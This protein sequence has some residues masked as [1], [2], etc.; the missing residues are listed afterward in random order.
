MQRD[1]HAEIA[2]KLRDRG[3][4]RTMRR[5]I[6]LLTKMAVTLVVTS[7]V[8]LAV[9]KIGTNGPDTLRGT[10]RADNLLGRDGNDILYGL[11]GKDNMLGGSGKDA[12]LGGNKRTPLKGEKNVVGGT[13]ND[14]ILGGQNSD[15]LVG[16]DG[17][18]YFYDGGVEGGPV[19]HD[20]VLGGDG[21]DVIIIFNDSSA[22][23]IAVCGDGI[24]RVLSD[25]LRLGEDTVAP[26]CEKVFVGRGAID[27]FN[28]SIPQ[29]FWDGLPP[30]P[31]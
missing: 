10:N 8:A 12:I 15:N 4:E 24:D 27:E 21:N 31:S 3:K 22:E 30:F 9:T 16:G 25:N 7:G 6:V 29:S 2:T 20:K 5:F 26:D 28:E 17:N 14:L 18:D 11:A 23:D 19:A 13:G 1:H